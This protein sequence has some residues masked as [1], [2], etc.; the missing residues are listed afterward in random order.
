MIEISV[1]SF[2]Y[3]VGSSSVSYWLMENLF[4][5]LVINPVLWILIA[6]TKLGIIIA[7]LLY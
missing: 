6:T 4:E 7:A 5:F 3:G 2:K 1:N